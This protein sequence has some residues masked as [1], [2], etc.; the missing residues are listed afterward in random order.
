MLKFLPALEDGP[1]DPP[2]SFLMAG[3]GGGTSSLMAGAGGVVWR[4]C[5][6]SRRTSLLENSDVDVGAGGGTSSLMAGV[7]GVKEGD[8]ERI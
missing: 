6:T 8:L 5:R 7:G 1:A 2:M 3:A 4:S